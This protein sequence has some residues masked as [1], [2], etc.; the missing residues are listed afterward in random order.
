MA[1]Q[2][3][4]GRRSLFIASRSVQPHLETGQADELE[5]SDHCD[6]W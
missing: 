6:D 1:D 2:H 3:D 4:L 5:T